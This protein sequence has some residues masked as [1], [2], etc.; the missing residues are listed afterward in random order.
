M[1]ESATLD[2]RRE[3]R[4]TPRHESERHPLVD[5]IKSIGN[6]VKYHEEIAKGHEGMARSL[7]GELA[8]LKRQAQREGIELQT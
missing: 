2:Q 8:A 3:Y 7:K 6:Q 5:R 1:N 4:V